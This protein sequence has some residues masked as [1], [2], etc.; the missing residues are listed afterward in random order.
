MP[1]I[2]DSPEHT[3]SQALGDLVIMALDHGLM[4]RRDGEA[5]VPFVLVESGGAH[6]IRR[7]EAI[8][9]EQAVAEA[10]VFVAR[11]PGANICAITYD[12]TITMEG[13]KFDAVLVIACETGIPNTFVFAQRY[14]AVP[15]GVIGSAAFLGVYEPL[16]ETIS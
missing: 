3:F 15:F 6:Y 14:D 10:K 9:D 4:N 12:G 2:S 16:A 11:L 8:S 13:A 1:D 5:L 7:F